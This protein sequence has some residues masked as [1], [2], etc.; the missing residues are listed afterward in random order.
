MGR[1]PGVR[2]GAGTTLGR[3]MSPLRSRPGPGGQRDGSLQSGRTAEVP[4]SLL[5]GRWTVLSPSL[6]RVT[7]LKRCCPPSRAADGWHL[8]RSCR[9]HAGVCPH[10]HLPEVCSER[11][12]ELPHHLLSQT[13]G[14]TGVWP[15]ETPQPPSWKLLDSCYVPGTA[16]DAGAPGMEK[17]AEVSALAV[18]TFYRGKSR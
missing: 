8:H 12:G 16:L 13:H 2:R 17:S 11:Q 10:R 5:A 1:K 7:R 9:G 15:L 14:H 3:K 6:P 18:F 4:L